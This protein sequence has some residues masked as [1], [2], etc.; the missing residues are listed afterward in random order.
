MI[1]LHYQI[2]SN[3][4]FRPLPKVGVNASS[5]LAGITPD[6]SVYPSAV[7]ILI[8]IR[9]TKRPDSRKVLTWPKAWGTAKALGRDI[10][11]TM[12][13]RADKVVE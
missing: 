5:F 6:P 1:R 13:A 7:D 3:C 2:A 10:P 9:E 12:I 4:F 8:C 11:P